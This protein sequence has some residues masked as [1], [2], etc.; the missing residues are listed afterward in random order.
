MNLYID[1]NKI[2]ILLY[3]IINNIIII[4]IIIIIKC[5][6]Y[7]YTC[8]CLYN[9]YIITTVISPLEYGTLEGDS[10]V[11]C[12]VVYLYIVIYVYVYVKY[13]IF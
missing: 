1:I 10:P 13:F 6:I 2:I 3:W 4:L 7:L 9:L 11:S 12:S 8:I 5:K